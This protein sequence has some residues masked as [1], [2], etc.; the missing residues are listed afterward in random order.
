MKDAQ[1]SKA[2][3]LKEIALGVHE[4]DKLKEKEL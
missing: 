2:L 3:T 1:Q 4:G